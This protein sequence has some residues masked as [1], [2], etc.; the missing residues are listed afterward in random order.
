MNYKPIT[1]SFSSPVAINLTRSSEATK[2]G[3]SRRIE[4]LVAMDVTGGPVG[5][6]LG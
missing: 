2:T 5:E 4:P 3:G 1:C 6:G